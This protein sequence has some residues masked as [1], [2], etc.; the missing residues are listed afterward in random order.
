MDHKKTYCVHVAGLMEE[1]QIA[2]LWNVLRV[3]LYPCLHAVAH[4]VPLDG[5]PLQRPHRWAVNV[6]DSVRIPVN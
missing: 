1:K 2:D 6:V 5:I 3:A 4:S